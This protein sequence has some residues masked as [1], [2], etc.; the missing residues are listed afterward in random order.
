M[1]WAFPIR[2][3]GAPFAL[4]KVCLKA[5][6]I[7]ALILLTASA[8]WIVVRVL[9]TL[10]NVIVRDV[11]SVCVR[12]KFTLLVLVDILNHRPVDFVDGKTDNAIKVVHRAH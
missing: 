8:I 3:Q 4:K 12:V 6:D 10:L 7:L 11:A 1:S 9:G 2:L 5:S